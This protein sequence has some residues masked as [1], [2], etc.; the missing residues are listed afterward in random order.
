MSSVA[1]EGICFFR[2]KVSVLFAMKKTYHKLANPVCELS[3]HMECP[4]E[5]HWKSIGR[6]VGYLKH[7][8]E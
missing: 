2:Q 5:E 3:L 7:E 1:K 6:M 4:G 8:I